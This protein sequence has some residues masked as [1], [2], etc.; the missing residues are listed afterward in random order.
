MNWHEIF[1][2]AN[3]KLYWKIKPAVRVKIGDEAGNLHNT[4]YLQVMYKG[5]CYQVHV[6]IYE[7]HY[8]PIPSGMIIDHD[9][10]NRTNNYPGNL[11]LT[12]HAGNMRNKS[13]DKRNTSGVTGVRWY[14]KL[15]KWSARISVNGKLK[16]LGYFDTIKEASAAR[17][18]AKKLLGYHPNHGK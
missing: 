11:K 14:E 2:Y 10:R 18:R 8:G 7:M 3:G 5:K 9:D 16:H 1:E 6:I 12:N 13:M 4:G 15:G 17:E